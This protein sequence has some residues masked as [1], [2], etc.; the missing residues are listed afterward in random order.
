MKFIAA[1]TLILACHGIWA[2]NVSLETVKGESMDI[3]TEVKSITNKGIKTSDGVVIPYSTLQK[4]STADFDL[5]EKLMNKTGKQAYRHIQVQFTGDESAY[6]KRLEKLQRNRTGAEV[7]RAAGGIMTILGILSG[8]RGLTAA[9]LA[10][11]AA[12]NVAKSVNTYR[13]QDTQ[14]EML[15]D[16]DERQRE[17]EAAVAEKEQSDE[18]WMREEYGKENVDGL[19]ELVD[20][21]HDKALAY[22]SVGE[23]SKDANHRLSAIWLKAMIEEDRGNKE[24]AKAHFE[25]IVVFD[26]EIKDVKEAEKE[27]HILLKE[28]EEL[29]AEQ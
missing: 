24:E 8:D 13:T 4:I 12:G 25:Q 2:Q 5:F 23:L 19:I 22:A 1:I 20:G 16:L 10:T 17:Q 15:K 7:A 14:T 6:V 21:D 11:N 27:V 9:G 3:Q 18:E 26:P 28:V 29:R